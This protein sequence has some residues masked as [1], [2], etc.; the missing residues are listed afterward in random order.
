MRKLLIPHLQLNPFSSITKQRLQSRAAKIV[1][2]SNYDV[3]DSNLIKK[4][5]WP[6]V[7]DIIKNETATITYRALKY[8]LRP[9]HI[10]INRD[11]NG[12]L[13]LSCIPLELSNK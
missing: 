6:A 11:V 3:Y 10:V 5:N 1:I 13:E 9:F 12:L 4:L 2:N 7:T 8:S